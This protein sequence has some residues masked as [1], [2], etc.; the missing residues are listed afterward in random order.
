MYNIICSGQH[1]SAVIGR[2]GEGQ[3]V[4]LYDMKEC[5]VVEDSARSYP[6]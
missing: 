3:V 2:V 4:H 6:R 1:N 5:G